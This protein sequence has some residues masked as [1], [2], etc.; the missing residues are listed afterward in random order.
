MVD[1]YGSI[2]SDDD[3]SQSEDFL[4]H[5]EVERLCDTALQ[6]IQKPESLTM[7]QIQ[8]VCWGLLTLG[9]QVSQRPVLAS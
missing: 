9:R 2:L 6:G 3:E 4:T 8:E 7:G 1:H 5:A